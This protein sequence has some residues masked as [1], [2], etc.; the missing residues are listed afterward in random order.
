MFCDG[1]VRF[2]NDDIDYENYQRMGDH[3]DHLSLDSL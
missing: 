3:R 2:V 1:S